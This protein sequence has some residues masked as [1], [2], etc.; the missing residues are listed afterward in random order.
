VAGEAE[1]EQRQFMREMMIRFDRAFE[2]N[3]RAIERNS[4]AVEQVEI[5]LR[6]LNRQMDEHRREFRAEYEAQR[7]SLLAILDRLDRLNGNGGG[8][9]PAT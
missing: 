8:A 4:R 5:S 3:V 1:N 2:S 9:A 6:G 7:G